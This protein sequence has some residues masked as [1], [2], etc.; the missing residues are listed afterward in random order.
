ML[1]QDKPEDYVIA[2][3][4]MK[5]VREFIELSAQKLGWIKEKG[6]K[7]IIWE[8]SGVNEIGRRADTK[9]VVVRVDPRY[10][11]PTEVEQ[12][13][14]DPS[15]AR[16][17]LGWKSNKSLNQLIS[18]MIDEDSNDAKK[19]YLLMKKGFSVYNSN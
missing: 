9:E 19:D 5:S 7:G 18:E 1:Q 10:F 12:L 17:K 13:L 14:G 3:G 4:E 6:G 8:K 16:K 2:S 15:K 11:R